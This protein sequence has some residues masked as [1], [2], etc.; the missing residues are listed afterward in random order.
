M[1]KH[2]RKL[3]SAIL[4]SLILVTALMP[5]ASAQSAGDEAAGQAAYG[6][7]DVDGDG[8]VTTKD[9]LEIQKHLASVVVLNTQQLSAAD[10][11]G[12]GKVGVSDA[13]RIQ[14]YLAKM[15]GSLEPERKITRGEW[16]DML[17][18]SCGLPAANT[19]DDVYTD[20]TGSIYYESVRSLYA[21]GALPADL[22]AEFSPESAVSREFAAYTIAH[23]LG[24]QPE[25]YTL[26]CIDADSVRYQQEAYVVLSLGFLSLENGSFLPKKELTFVQEKQ[27]AEKLRTYKAGEKIDP[28]HKNSV[29][30][31]PGVRKLDNGVAVEES[32]TTVTLSGSGVPALKSGDVFVTEQAAYKVVNV[33]VSGGKTVVKTSQPQLYE[34]L[35][36]ADVQGSGYGDLSKA[37]ILNE[38]VQVVKAQTNK[39]RAQ[40]GEESQGISET[41][42]F[43]ISLMDGPLKGEITIPNPQ[44]DFSFQ[45]TVSKDKFDIKDLYLALNQECQIEVGV[46]QEAEIEL[47]LVRIPFMLNL[48]FW[49]QVVIGIKSTIGGKAVVT[50]TAEMSNGI[51]VVNNMPSLISDASIE[52]SYELEATAKVGGEG[53]ITLN[54]LFFE[55]ADVTAFCGKGVTFTP[56]GKQSEYANLCADVDSYNFAEISASIGGRIPGTWKLECGYR[57]EFNHMPSHWEDFAL[58][59][60]CTKDSPARPARPKLDIPDLGTAVVPDKKDF[61]YGPQSI[62]TSGGQSAYGMV[63]SSYRG[64]AS[65]IVIPSE[66]DGKPVVSVNFSSN[67]VRGITLPGTIEKMDLTG[68][69]NLEY[70]N[71]LPGVEEISVGAFNGCKKLRAVSLPNTLKR[72][73]ENAFNGSGITNFVMPDSVTMIR[74][75]I[76]S[77]CPNLKS[78][79]LSQ[80]LTTIETWTFLRS[81]LQAVALPEK[82]Q[83][84]NQEAFKECKNLKFI[85]LPKNLERIDFRAFQGSGLEKITVPGKAIIESYAFS[86]CANLKKA[87]LCD[88]IKSVPAA[89]F[90]NCG[91]LETVFLPRSVIK[92][93]DSAFMNCGSL[94][95]ISLP[96][97]LGFVSA[98]A[99]YNAGLR[100]VTIPGSAQL[101]GNSLFGVFA[102]CKDLQRAI[103]LEGITS[104]PYDLFKNC[105]SLTEVA[106]PKSA[107][108]IYYGAFAGCTAMKC[109]VLRGS[110]TIIADG[111]FPKDLDSSFIVGAPKNSTG[112]SFAQ[113]NRY[114][115]KEIA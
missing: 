43:Y 104:V 74:A 63:I 94:R 56:L 62:T 33:S 20:I 55:L 54:W 73:Y 48:G 70:A 72:I 22:A 44:L 95:D 109:V 83:Y 100:T 6:A 115:F 15:I 41:G 45:G 102:G 28:D 1:K 24:Y 77:D 107:E 68:L 4:A 80:N 10:V 113:E 99:F 98:D 17:V 35:K 58:L 50:V 31:A 46:E 87:A 2:F 64:N 7:G 76:L 3:L 40:A 29:E 19:Q 53:K 9:V 91:A 81:G 84:I 78:V 108:K 110:N 97:R 111:S 26:S 13:L 106:I 101:S 37:E 5:A 82:L 65:N 8:T 89:A 85:M 30:Y 57:Q 27:I 16:A 59:P 92:I 90:Q 105:P 47:P 75:R 112:E 38:N 52:A 69:K 61:G 23:A 42:E 86:N 71:I 60:E 36:S 49:T 14:Q 66:I 93:G 96:Y 32:G 34:V 103:L 12:D 39:A 88:G 51:R 18:S 79:Y 25:G 114:R 11:T 21:C 67:Y